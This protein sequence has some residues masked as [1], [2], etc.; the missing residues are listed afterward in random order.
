MRRDLIERV[1][2]EIKRAVAKWGE[3]DQIPDN[4]ISAAVEELGETAHA[5]NHN[6]GLERTQQEICETIGVLARLYDMVEL[7]Q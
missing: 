3:H 5:I 2:R 7:R 4:L 6:E 1:D